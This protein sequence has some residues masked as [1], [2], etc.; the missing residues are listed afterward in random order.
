MWSFLVSEV[1]SSGPCSFLPGAYT[2][3]AGRYTRPISSHAVQRDFDI[4]LAPST[5]VLL[6]SSFPMVWGA[7]RSAPQA[8]H[9][10]QYARCEPSFCALYL[11]FNQVHLPNGQPR[12]LST[13]DVALFWERF[14]RPARE[15]P[16]RLSSCFSSIRDEPAPTAAISSC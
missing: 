15:T 16:H 11:R 2:L 3:T 8:R 9:G 1:M 5:P 14:P 4:R 12:R 7:L 13:L 10:A 6:F